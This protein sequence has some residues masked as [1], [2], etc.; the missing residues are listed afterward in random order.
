MFVDLNYSKMIAEKLGHL[1]YSSFIKDCFY[2][3]SVVQN[4]NAAIYQYVGDEAV[5]TWERSKMKSALE[6]IDAFWAFDDE[7]LKRSSYYKNTYG[8]VPEFKAG[9]S[10]GMVTVVEIGNF[11]KE[12]A[13]HGNTVTTASRIESISNV[14]GE[15]VMVSTTLNDDI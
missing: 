14:Y 11:K 1:S 8:I 5:L 7:L 13:Y 6:C 10:I 3:L 2:D 12:I 9:M 15:K 4:Y